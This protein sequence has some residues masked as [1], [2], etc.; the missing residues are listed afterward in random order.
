MER[1]LEILQSLIVSKHKQDAN[2]VLDEAWQEAVLVTPRHSLYIRRAND[3][4]KGEKLTLEERYAAASKRTQKTG[5]Q[6]RRGNLPDTVEIA[7]GLEVMVTLNIETELDVA[8][9]SRGTIQKIIFDPREPVD[10]TSRKVTLQH[11]PLCILVKIHRTKAHRIDRLDDGVIPI[12]PFQQKYSLTRMNQPSTQV[13]RR[14]LPIT[15]ADAFTDY[16]SQGQT[17]ERVIIDI[18]RP[19]SG[20][21][22]PSN[23]Y[24]A[25]S[26]SRGR[27]TIRLLHS[28]IFTKTPCEMLK[29][30]E[31]RLNQL[32]EETERVWMQRQSHDV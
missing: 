27:N 24:V 17:I 7:I 10:T 3:T 11:L 15:S 12:V 25:L 26:R 32:N 14:Q 23:A 20:S 2:C 31:E 28:D 18:A 8:N 29:I 13:A 4:I 6:N 1:D 22:T 21:I 30:E 19:P 16:R 9:G 5:G